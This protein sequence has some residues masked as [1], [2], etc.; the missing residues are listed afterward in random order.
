MR[1]PVHYSDVYKTP[2]WAKSKAGTQA[3]YPSGWQGFNYLNY[4]L[5]PPRV[6][7]AGSWKQEQR[8]DLNRGEA[9]SNGILIS[10]AVLTNQCEAQ[11]PYVIKGFEDNLKKI[12]VGR[13]PGGSGWLRVSVQEKWVKQN[14][15]WKK[16]I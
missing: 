12:S 5:L 3:G 9:I 10:T 4:Y 7:N 2:D 6:H 8:R 16:I 1:L 11:W 14:Y 13:Y 15:L